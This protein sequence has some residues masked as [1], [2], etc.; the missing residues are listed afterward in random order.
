MALNLL[1]NLQ[2]PSPSGQRHMQEQ[3]EEVQEAEF[4][5][6]DLRPLFRAHSGGGARK[7]PSSS[8][9]PARV[10]VSGLEKQAFHAIFKTNTPWR[11]EGCAAASQA[12]CAICLENFEDSEQV[13]VM[14]SCRGHEF[15]P[16]CTTKWLGKSNTCPLSLPPRFATDDVMDDNGL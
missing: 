10:A 7:A 3:A 8:P 12:G 1:W 2:P 14:P 16:D 5:D 9:R 6:D 13:T 15:H 4:L 11:A